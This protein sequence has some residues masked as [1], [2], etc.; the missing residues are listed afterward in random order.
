M[1]VERHLCLTLRG[2][3]KWST[4]FYRVNRLILDKEKL[5]SYLNTQLKLHDK[6]EKFC[7][8]K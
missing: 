8:V 4:P 5:T 2:Y 1:D 3:M 7:L 6:G